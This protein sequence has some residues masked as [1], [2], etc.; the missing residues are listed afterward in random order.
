MDARLNV[1]HCR[2]LDI[3]EAAIIADEPI[4]ASVQPLLKEC[5]PM[6]FDALEAR[7]RREL[8][9]TPTDYAWLVQPEKVARRRVCTYVEALIVSQQH[10][11]GQPLECNTHH[12]LGIECRSRIRTNSVRH[13]ER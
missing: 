9:Y 12:L 7:C 6:S 8:I 4:Y 13:L 11:I 3:T 1:C 10:G 2:E 5:S